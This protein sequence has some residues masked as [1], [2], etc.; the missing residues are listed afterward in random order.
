MCLYAAP[1]ARK[2]KKVVTQRTTTLPQ[3]G[4]Q[5]G[6]ASSGCTEQLARFFPD[7]EAV[8]IAVEVTPLRNGAGE[9]RETVLV[10][11]ASAETMIF[12]ATLPL[13][14]AD[15]IRLLLAEGSG[16][17]EATVVAVQYHEGRKAI[18]VQFAERQGDW[19]KRP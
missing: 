4:P 1:A 8:R 7:A 9:F 10:E 16:Q 6:Q 17:S 13:E 3:A 2:A 5:R 12:S 18:A 14:F 11:Y 19:V 15:R